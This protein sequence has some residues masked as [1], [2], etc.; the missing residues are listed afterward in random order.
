MNLAADSATFGH[1]PST[2]K[3]RD[4]AEADG[5]LGVDSETP[6]DELFGFPGASVGATDDSESLMIITSLFFDQT[7]L[8]R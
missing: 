1:E 4:L 2:P 3:I 5:E 8:S 6:L 7:A